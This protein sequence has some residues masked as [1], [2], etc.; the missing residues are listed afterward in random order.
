M[1]L[2]LARRARSRSQPGDGGAV[3]LHAPWRHGR[4]R[5]Q[6]GAA[7]GGGGSGDQTRAAMEYR[8]KGTDMPGLPRAEPQQALR[9]ARPQEPPRAARSFH[10]LV[11]TAGRPRREQPSRRDG[12]PRGRL[13]DAL[14]DQPAPLVLRASISGFGQTGPWASAPGVRPH[15]AGRMSGI[16]SATGPPPTPDGGRARQGDD[17]QSPTSARASSRSTASFPPSTGR[18]SSGRGQYVDTSLFER[19]ARPVHLGDHRALGEAASRRGPS[20]TAKPHE[21]ALSGGPILRRPFSSSA[22]RT[23]A[24]GCACATS[25]RPRRPESRDPRFRG[26]QRHA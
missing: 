17:A 22:R 10:A 12:T 1:T 23:S 8:Y 5:H 6:G 18:A 15:R 4:R 26:Q 20:G 25:P 14:T 3:R 21:R 11:K 19:G 2:P 9:H 7:G 13:R 16:M 24:C